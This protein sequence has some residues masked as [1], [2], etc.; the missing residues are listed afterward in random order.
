MT[1]REDLENRIK[2]HRPD[3]DGIDRIAQ[4]RRYAL[5][6]SNAIRQM[7]PDGREQAVA[8][9]KIEEAMFWANAGIARDRDH[10]AE[11]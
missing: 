2:Y 3:Q 11:D 6:W 5:D 8:F 10:W 4:M 7:V 1:D 9:T